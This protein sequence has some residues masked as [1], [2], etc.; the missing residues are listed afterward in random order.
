MIWSGLDEFFDFIN[1]N[2]EYVILRNWENIPSQNLL[3]GKDDIDILCS[4]KETF[5]KVT[6]AIPLFHKYN[7]CNYYVNMSFGRIRIDIRSIGDGYYCKEWEEQFLKRRFLCEKGFYILDSEDYFYSLAYHGLIQKPMFSPIYSERLNLMR[8]NGGQL[9]DETEF[10]RMLH[11]YMKSNSFYVEDPLDCAVHLN[12]R[13]VR[14]G[15]LA[16]KKNV[17]RKINRIMYRVHNRILRL[18][19]KTMP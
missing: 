12:Q 15:N 1:N 5:V 2:T 19:G 7:I 4:N 6:D 11:E 8:D 3:S 9:K 13:N 18:L 16:A 14:T 17:R 10:L